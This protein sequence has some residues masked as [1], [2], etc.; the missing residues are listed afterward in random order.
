V[1]KKKRL[2]T[3]YR[4]T[5]RMHLGHYEGNLK[6]MLA[7]QGKYE[8]F[9][10]IA[11]WHAMTT[12]YKDLSALK[13][14]TEEMVLDWLAVGLDPAHSHIYKQSAI[15]EIAEFNLY[16]SMITP[17]GWLERNTTYKDQLR[18][19]GARL[20]S[21]YGFL[22]YPVLQAADIMIMH[23]DLVPVGEDQLPHLELARE[24]ARRFNHLYGDYLKEPEAVLSN[25]PK[26]VGLDGRKM[27]KSYGNAIY[28]SDSAQ[29]IEKKVK[30][31]ITDPAM[32][33]ANDPGHPD[34]C[35]VF[36]AQSVFNDSESGQI[37]QD[38]RAGSIGCVECKRALTQR[39]EAITAPI[40]Q[41]REELSTENGIVSE[42]LDK[43]L[44]AVKPVAEATLADV[45]GRLSIS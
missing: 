32:I 13:K 24:I 25:I 29:E 19:L 16:L 37:A 45:R 10:F 40:R 5:G 7:A 35:S 39:I 3:G 44:N 18:E 31:M 15:P 27:S 36:A 43:G 12:K 22:G 34:V 17:L 8:C 2:L 42:V 23:A 33:R 4:P 20:A 11:D 1:E 21:T 30:M 6:N 26:V 28:L 41:K 38:C 14:D 9:F